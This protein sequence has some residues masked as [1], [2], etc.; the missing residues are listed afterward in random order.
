MKKIYFSKFSN[1][2]KIVKNPKYLEYGYISKK[3]KIY[4]NLQKAMGPR[5]IDRQK[6]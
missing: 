2:P 3:K 4:K 6:R 1:I 5:I